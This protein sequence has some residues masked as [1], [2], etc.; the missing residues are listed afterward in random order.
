MKKEYRDYFGVKLGD[1]GKPFAPLVC[2]KWYV[3]NQNDWRNS[4]RKFCHLIFQ[5]SW[6]KENIA[7]RTLNLKKINRKNKYHVQYSGAPFAMR[8]IPHKS[9]LPVHEPDDNVV[10]SSDFKHSAMTVVAGDDTYK[11]EGDDQPLPLTQAEINNLTW[12][13]NLSK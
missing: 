13:P 7:L 10:Y 5:W 8:P 12:D 4:Q 11:P 9:D 1:R 2:C 3:E 6:D